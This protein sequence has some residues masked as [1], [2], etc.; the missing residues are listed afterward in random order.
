MHHAS[1]SN[2]PRH[3][4][5]T[6]AIDKHGGRAPVKA[7]LRWGSSHLAGTGVAYR[8]PAE[9]LTPEAGE[10][11]AAPRALSD[12]AARMAALSGAGL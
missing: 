2:S 6:L 9:C 10:E 7:E 8:H 11:L 3:P 4:I 5:V 12:R 1:R